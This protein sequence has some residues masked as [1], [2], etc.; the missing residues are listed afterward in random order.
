MVDDTVR[1]S[2]QTLELA[3]RFAGIPTGSVVPGSIPAF[4]KASLLVVCVWW[5]GTVSN[6]EAN[7]GM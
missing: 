2:F 4:Q 3:K 6:E 5:Q 7:Q 1:K